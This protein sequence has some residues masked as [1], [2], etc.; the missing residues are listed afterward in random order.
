MGILIDILDDH[1]FF[2]KDSPVRL[3][4]FRISISSCWNQQEN[5]LYFKMFLL[6]KV[7]WKTKT[8]VLYVSGPISY[9]CATIF[10]C[11]LMKKDVPVPGCVCI[12]I[13]L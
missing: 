1:F 2:L 9:E 13:W 3:N 4:S 7:A 11:E 12:R 10:K 6:T 5:V 8:H